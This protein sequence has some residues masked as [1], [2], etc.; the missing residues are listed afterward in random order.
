MGHYRKSE[1]RSGLVHFCPKNIQP[2]RPRALQ[3]LLTDQ[4]KV[5]L[6]VALGY[7][8]KAIRKATSG[9]TPVRVGETEAYRRVS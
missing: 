4:R 2:T 9:A 6:L 3:H 7:W 8:S 1:S 5:R